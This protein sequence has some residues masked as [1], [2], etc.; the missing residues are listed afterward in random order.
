MH[1]AAINMSSNPTDQADD[2]RCDQKCK[3]QIKQDLGYTHRRASNTAESE[4]AGNKR[5]DQKDESVV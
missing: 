5:D 1:Q 4:Y 3:E 2:N